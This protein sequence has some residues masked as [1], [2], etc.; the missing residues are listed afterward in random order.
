MTKPPSKPPGLTLN[1]S[2]FS[3]PPYPGPL[4]T[5]KQRKAYEQYKAE[6][7]KRPPPVPSPPIERGPGL[8]DV[9]RKGFNESYRAG[10][11]EGRKAKQKASETP[12]VV[13]D[14]AILFGNHRDN[15]LSAKRAR[16]EVINSLV[17]RG[18]HPKTAEN[19]ATAAKAY[20]ENN[21]AAK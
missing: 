10:L 12:G 7:A 11:E 13:E 9:I 5:P 21:L 18:V 16:R 1:S 3:P 4:A 6:L 2:P 8:F 19:R 14:D 15:G 20:W 17:E